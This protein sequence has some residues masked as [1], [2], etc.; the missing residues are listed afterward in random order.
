MGRVLS[1]EKI[2]KINND[3]PLNQLV[4]MGD[5]VDHPIPFYGIVTLVKGVANVPVYIITDEQVGEGRQAFVTGMQFINSGA[6]AWTD[7]TA[8]KVTIEDSN[9]D[10]VTAIAKAGITASVIINAIGGTNQ[11]LGAKQI[12][13]AGMTA[14]KGIRVVADAVF[15]AGTDLKIA[16]WGFIK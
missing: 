1:N 12:A 7:T 11:T 9:G 8:T 13:G 14:G 15:V 10:D 6:T 16:V 2:A 5:L 3:S 4:K